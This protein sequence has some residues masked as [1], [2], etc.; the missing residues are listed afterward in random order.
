MRLALGKELA[1]S[2]ASLAETVAL[3]EALRGERARAQETLE[4]AT[5]RLADAE[6]AHRVQESR[7]AEQ[8]IRG[9]AMG[10][11]AALLDVVL[12]SVGAEIERRR[13]R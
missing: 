11:A 9:D 6:Q 8:T 13:G 4:A 2:A 5:R 1:R 7:R 10:Q 12:A 3:S